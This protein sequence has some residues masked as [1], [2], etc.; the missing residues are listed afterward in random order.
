[1]GRRSG[2]GDGESL[3]ASKEAGSAMSVETGR[4]AEADVPWAATLAGSRAFRVEAGGRWVP[5][6]RITEARGPAACM[7][8]DALFRRSLLA[9]DVAAL[10]FALTLTVGVSARSLQLTWASIACVPVLLFWAKITGL[11][12]RDESLI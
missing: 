2:D 8:R 1:M 10:V 5:A 9:A 7:R 6:L 3:R 11:Y 12:D 4:G